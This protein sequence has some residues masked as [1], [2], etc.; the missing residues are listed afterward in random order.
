MNPRPLSRDAVRAIDRRAADDYGLPTLLLMENAGR[1]AAA[2]LLEQQPVGPIAIVCG[3]GNNAGDGFVMARH[4]E[5]AGTRPIVY[6][7]AAADRYV[8]D[9]AI[10]LRILERCGMPIHDH[11]AATP[12]S[13]R[14]ALATAGWIV[15]ALLGTGAVGEVRPPLAD[16]IA[17]INELGR[18]VF[19]VDLPSG[20]DADTGRPQGIAIRATLTGTFVA[21]KQGFLTPEAVAWTG[22]VVVLDIG[23]PRRLLIE[24][25]AWDDEHST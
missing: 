25:G 5:L 16:L 12:E 24:A 6:L 21:P 13:W 2:L 9:A 4:L 19:A 14:A 7:T 15:D 22:R 1:N 3:K 11:S 17:V 8:G 10:N 23:A 18:P 20:L